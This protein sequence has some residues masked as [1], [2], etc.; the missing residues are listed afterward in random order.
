MARSSQYRKYANHGADGGLGEPDT[1]R[2]PTVGPAP[3]AAGVVI[4]TPGGDLV[5]PAVVTL[6]GTW[7]IDDRLTIDLTVDAGVGSIQAQ[8]T[9]LSSLTSFEMVTEMVNQLNTIAAGADIVA[10]QNGAA[11]EILALAPSATVTVDSAVIDEPV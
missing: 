5:T 6:S 10:A 7:L 2:G 8:Y 4:T 1:G 11:I 9:P 3:A